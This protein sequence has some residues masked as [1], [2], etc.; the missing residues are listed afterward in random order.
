M[1]DNT[2]IN[3]ALIGIAR[4]AE[5][6]EAGILVDTFVNVGPLLAVLS[7]PNHQVVFGRRGTG[8]THALIYMLEKKR[9]K[10]VV[11][12]FVDL[13]TIGSSGGIYGDTTISIPE[14]GTRLLLDV[15]GSFTGT[16]CKSA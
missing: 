12:V 8:K 14:R 7:S 4:R 2:Q 9:E 10:G 1:A 3:T 11:G 6:I 13:R 16:F 5:T 15:L